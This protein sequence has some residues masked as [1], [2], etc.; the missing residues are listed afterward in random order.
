MGLRFEAWTFPWSATFQR[1]IADIPVAVGVCSGEV[2]HN[3]SGAE[4]RIAVPADYDRL[5]EIISAT[6]G[7]LIRVYDGTTIIQEFLAERVP[8]RIEGTALVEISGP[9]LFEVFDRAVVY[10]YDYP[11][12]PSKFP[13]HVYGGRNLLSNPSG[14]A[15]VFNEV[16]RI[17]IDG[18]YRLTNLN[19]AITDTQTTVTVDDAT[20]FFESVDFAIL[21]DSEMMKV[22]AVAGN[23]LTVTRGY[24]GTTAA[25][26]TDNTRVQEVPSGTFALEFDGQTT[27]ALDW[28][29]HGS[30]ANHTDESELAAALKALT[31]IIDVGVEIVETYDSNGVFDYAYINVEFLDP[32][33]ADVAQMQLR[34]GTGSGAW[35]DTL[36]S[37]AAMNVATRQPGGVGDPHPWTVS[38]EPNT[39]AEHGTYGATPIRATDT[40][41]GEPADAIRVDP[42]SI[43]GG[44][45]QIIKVSAGALAQTSIQVQP[46][47]TGDYRLVIR[48][49][50]GKH[51]ASDPGPSS[52]TTL[53]A[54]SFTTMT[55][56]NI[57]IPADTSQV[58]VRV[59]TVDTDS[60]AWAPFYFKGAVFE[61][62]LGA[63][64]WGKILGDL[65]DD[66]AVDHAADTRGTILDWVDYSSFTDT[67]DSSGAA[68][69]QDENVTVHRGMTYG[70]LLDRG[71]D[72]GYE[73]E[74]RP[75]TVPAGGKTHDLKAYNSGNLGTDHTTAATP[76]VNAGQSTVGGPVIDR[77]P[78]YTAVLVEGDEGL[79][80]E[81]SDAT[82]LS[83][84]GRFESY[85]GDRAL[86]SSASL[87][88]RA[89]ELL[90]LEQSNRK[91]V[92]AEVVASPDHPRPLVDYR[93]GDNIYF[94]L[95]P[96]LSKTARRIQ[97]I[98]WRNTEPARYTVTGSRV[99]DGEAGAYEAIRRLLRR[100][101][102]LADRETGSGLGAEKAPPTAPLASD[103]SG[104]YIH[105]SRA[106][107]Q[108]IAVGGEAISWDNQ[109]RTPVGFAAVSL[110]ET[111]ITIVK[112]G[113]Y[114][115][116]VTAGW[117]THNAGGT[118]TVI[119]E[120]AGV[121]VTVW[122]PAADP[123]IWTASDG[124]IFEGVAHAIP[125]DIGDILRVLIDHDAAAAKDLA[126]ATLAVYLVDRATPANLRYR[127]VVIADSPLAYWR[128]GESAGPA[129]VDET[130]NGYDGTYAG[131]PTFSVSPLISDGDTDTAVGFDTDG[132]NV[133]DT[134]DLEFQGAVPFTVEAWVRLD[135]AAAAPYS[136]V[137]VHKE[138]YTSQT[139]P[140]Q[141]WVLA[142]KTDASGDVAFSF[143]RW[144]GSSPSG[145]QAAL[146]AYVFS[147]GQTYHVVGIFDGT[148]ARIY[149]DGAEIDSDATSISLPATTTDLQIGQRTGSSET[150]DGT[151]DEV[152]VYERALTPE[153]V[154][155]HWY[156]GSGGG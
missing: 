90:T 4:A 82:A 26:H 96:A 139:G 79:I 53:T 17:Y 149:V 99:F 136:H 100:F 146:S 154:A 142:A 60:A 105:L 143:E 122:P 51:I 59:A 29:P 78:A 97:S 120:R 57:Q 72:L 150:L 20:V 83:N 153:E 49:L 130:G 25:A 39:G 106:T 89:T 80:H 74:L 8:R 37:V 151:I 132:V 84:F 141:G 36:Y 50:N 18:V 75:K 152:A 102:P 33:E 81:D 117:A 135:P 30:A 62:G 101:T 54:G 92:K 38:R 110:P 14:T 6:T 19:G 2:R 114:D 23:D 144:N 24:K 16:Q 123:G 109:D 42:T 119:R 133:T 43:Y 27:A 124:Q 32:G 22:T 131:T 61:E 93:P 127:S 87:T 85:A 148:T 63:S 3:Q 98:A 67:L 103:V 73:H 116:A 125:C 112:P 94:Q 77:I 21:V 58:I 91:A 126:S 137:I 76:A 35:T 64:K 134:V 115:I 52:G 11:T 7:S 108:T 9:D 47:V 129:A 145:E 156:V 46:T 1:K 66:A 107:A 147:R 10:P 71:V 40:A 70:Q 15:N 155:E 45:Q 28:N 121:A 44:G 69:P 65:L 48:D 56:P 113:Y 88:G 128:L 13:N 31:N 86:G 111:D 118:V 138:D 95:P 34:S 5:D 55:I 41:L 104:A 140:N 68:W 12:S